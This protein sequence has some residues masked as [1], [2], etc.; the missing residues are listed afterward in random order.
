MARV[1]LI[2][3]VVVVTLL[4]PAAPAHAAAEW[5]DTDPLL[6]IRTPDGG[7]VTV[8]LLVGA[9]GAEHLPAVLAASLLA[10]TEPLEATEGRRALRVIA[11]VTVPNDLFGPGFPTRALVTSGPLGSGAVYAATEGASGAPMTLRFTL[12]MP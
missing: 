1:L 2:A 11:T 7:V 6:L 3:L 9:L 5:C 10:A 12:P 4:A 8:Y